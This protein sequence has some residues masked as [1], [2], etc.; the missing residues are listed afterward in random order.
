MT[1]LTFFCVDALVLGIKIQKSSRKYKLVL[2]TIIILELVQK[3]Y[4]WI[5]RSE[6]LL[7]FKN[8]NI[9]STYLH[10]E[11]YLAAF[12]K[13][14]ENRTSKSFCKERNRQHNENGLEEND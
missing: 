11:H 12:S 2:Q 14:S 1:F 5:H 10:F 9:L 7:L 13:I 4:G 3:I 8:K 6:F